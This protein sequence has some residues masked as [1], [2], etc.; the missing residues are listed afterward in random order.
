M[1][2]WKTTL[3][4]LL[5]AVGVAL[6]QTHTGGIA[7]VILTA[8]G[9][10]LVGLFSTDA[11]NHNQVSGRVRDE[12]GLLLLI[13]LF[14]LA[15]VPSNLHAK[16]NSM[17]ELIEPAV[18]THLKS[19]L[20]LPARSVKVRG[21]KSSPLET[22]ATPHVEA[23]CD[24]GKDR[25]LNQ[26]RT[27]F[28]TELSL[29]VMLQVKNMRSDDFR[30]K[31]VYPFLQIAKSALSGERL[32]LDIDPIVP[33][34]DQN[35]STEDDARAGVMTWLLEFSTSYQWCKLED[36]SIDDLKKIILDN[37]LGSTDEGL[38]PVS[39]EIALPPLA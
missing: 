35:V 3:S 8:L 39:S 15:I 10:L 14:A 20:S 23:F 34:R 12:I 1:K 25:P 22:L 31:A 38:P 18:V 37:Y 36:E 16:E 26:G 6:S 33:V 30:R 21:Q 9:V 13:G 29:Y 28:E 17:R 5:A 27:S 24:T 19:K 11:S 4:G 7:G 32:G 2:H